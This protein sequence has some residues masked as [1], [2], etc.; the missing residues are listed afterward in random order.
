[1]GMGGRPPVE[2]DK[3]ILYVFIELDDPPHSTREIEEHL[4]IGYQGTYERLYELEEKG[5]VELKKYG[6]GLAWRITDA[7]REYVESELSGES[8]DVGAEDGNQ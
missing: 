7:G 8:E 1:M 4:R 2:S 3:R 6:A 5:Y